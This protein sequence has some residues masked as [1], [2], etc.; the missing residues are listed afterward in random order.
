[1]Y[2]HYQFF[3]GRGN[4]NKFQQQQYQPSFQQASFSQNSLRR[5]G[6]ASNRSRDQKRGEERREKVS[7]IVS[8]EIV[9]KAKESLFQGLSEDDLNKRMIQTSSMKALPL[10]VTTRGVGFGTQVL[11]NVTKKYR[12]G[13]TIP[14]IKSLYRA[15]LGI[16][17][18]KIIESN[19]GEVI[20]DDSEVKRNS[21]SQDY[22]IQS[23]AVVK[24]PE[25]IN[26]IVQ[27]IGRV[28]NFDE[29][30]IPC[31]PKDIVDVNGVFV[32]VPETVVLSNL[33]KTVETIR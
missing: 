11:A 3:R 18:C 23:N 6:S 27:S 30:Y 14:D 24:L 26:R 5:R 16:L 20:E 7:D 17:E 33:R 4:R 21:L 9:V 31:L 25:P 32:P 15:F 28:S 22:I 10:A 1:M 2:P 13:I 29:S 19:F 8:Q 12:D